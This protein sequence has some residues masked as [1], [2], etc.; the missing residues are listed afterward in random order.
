MLS[1]ELSGLK[2]KNP[3][4]LASGILGSK[5][6]SLKRVAEFAGAV[7]AKSVGAEP[8]EGYRNPAVLNGKCCIV[9]AVGLTSPGAE[10][11]SEELQL[12]STE[13]TH[14]I[15]SLFASKAEEFASLV[16]FFPFASA[17]EL[18]LSCPHAEKLGMAVGVD[19]KAVE[20][21]VR[22]VK[23]ATDKPVFA[24]LTPNVT[25][26]T[27]IALSAEKGN[28]DGVVVVNTLK[29]IAIDIYSKKPVLSN[30]RGGL[31]GRAIK[32]LALRCVWDLY[33]VLSIPVIGCGGISSW[34]DV[35]EFM[36]AGAK[37]VQIGSAFYYSPRVLE[38]ICASLKEYLREENMKAEELVGLAHR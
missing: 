1:V 17:F 28:A 14:L 25:D 5:A 35:V 3:L 26:I 38:S 34:K 30:V 21:C 22:A 19:E 10:K 33:E 11:F 9:N 20:E 29:A 4:M 37:A 16:D 18:N 8:R 7:V 23:D 6:S 24:K 2:M 36:L 12:L 32:S 27:K 13:K 15:V 31:S